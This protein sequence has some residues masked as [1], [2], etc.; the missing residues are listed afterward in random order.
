MKVQ[1]WMVTKA[2]LW[3]LRVKDLLYWEER[4]RSSALIPLI[5]CKKKRY[6]TIL[7]SWAQTRILVCFLQ[8]F[9]VPDFSE[10]FVSLQE[11]Q[12]SLLLPLMV[13][14]KQCI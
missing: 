10:T 7:D 8:D 14:F 5:Y 13:V 12:L 2:A 3:S 6:N 9:I 11:Q 1:R 4:V